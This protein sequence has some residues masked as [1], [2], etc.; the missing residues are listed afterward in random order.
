[1]KLIILTRLGQ[2]ARGRWGYVECEAV[3]TMNGLDACLYIMYLRF[4]TDVSIITPMVN[5]SF[6]TAFT[7]TDIDKFLVPVRALVLMKYL[8]EEEIEIKIEQRNRK[9]GSP[10]EIGRVY[11]W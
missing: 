11:Y 7:K 5:A 1:L 4:T 6:G 10:V 8:I 2:E 9:Y 3:E